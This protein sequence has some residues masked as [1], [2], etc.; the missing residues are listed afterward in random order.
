[1]LL[2]FDTSTTTAVV[3][4]ARPEGE[5]LIGT[6]HYP[7]GEGG[8]SR[9]LEG[10]L[11]I[12]EEAGG[13]IS[14]LTGL[15][16]SRGPG[17]YTGLRIGYSL[18]QGLVESLRLPVATI[19]SW[20]AF[21][22]QYRSRTAALCVC[23]NARSR[24][25]AWITYLPGEDRPLRRS[26]RGDRAQ[27][28]VRAEDVIELGEEGVLLQIAPA[29][30]IPGFVPRPCRLVGPGVGAFQVALDHEPPDDVEIISGS[31]RAGPVHLLKLGAVD[32]IDGGEDLLQTLP[33]Y[34]GTME[35]APRRTE[36]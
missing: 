25:T 20:G 34:L 22:D 4:L 14:L 11:E 13:D 12:L 15:V 23:F 3:A 28:P 6:R 16:I 1:M 32:L 35:A 21:A 24:G 5:P 29:E 7:R 27:Y 36:S 31:E 9:L 33:F 2:L 8:S 26:E 17:S 18:A 19:P 30:A 10:A